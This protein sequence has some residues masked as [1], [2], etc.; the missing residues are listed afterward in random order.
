[1]LASRKKCLYDCLWGLRWWASAIALPAVV[2]CLRAAFLD[3]PM[4]SFSTRAKFLGAVQRALA[5]VAQTTTTCGCGCRPCLSPIFIPPTAVRAASKLRHSDDDAITRRR[6]KYHRPSASTP[7][8]PRPHTIHTTTLAA[9]PR[10]PGESPP[11]LLSASCSEPRARMCLPTPV[12]PRIY[13]R[14]EHTDPLPYPSRQQPRR[15][16]QLPATG[17]LA[18]QTACHRYPHSL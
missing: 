5:G 13:V 17:H 9:P 8:P 4:E 2:Q 10:R 6:P 3:L 14:R 15:S 7:P 1:M 11:R 12:A 16:L 18:K